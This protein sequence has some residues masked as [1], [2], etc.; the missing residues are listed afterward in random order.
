MIGKAIVWRNL[1]EEGSVWWWVIMVSY[2][3]DECR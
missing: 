3:F 1:S 2:S